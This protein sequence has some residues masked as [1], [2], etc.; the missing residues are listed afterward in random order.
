MH[1]FVSEKKNLIKRNELLNPYPMYVTHSYVD[2]PITN[3]KYLFFE[4]IALNSVNS[5][6]RSRHVSSV[7]LDKM[8]CPNNFF[9]KKTNTK[10]NAMLCHL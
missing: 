8:A 10:K 6:A 7:A 9:I 3:I 2:Y 1:V 4:R 5:R